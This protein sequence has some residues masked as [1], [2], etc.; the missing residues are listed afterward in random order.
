MKLRFI[1]PFFLTLCVI[2]LFHYTQFFAVKFYPV[3]ANFTAFAVFFVSSFS[4]ETVIQKFAKMLEG[5]TLDDFTRNYTRRLTYVWCVFCFLNL[6]ISIATVFMTEKWWA[7]YN[8]F[9]SYLALGTMF[10][11]EYIVRV[12]LRKK[13]QK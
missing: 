3:I 11:V 10:A 2:L 7:L 12:V 5:G 1:L 4:E 9:I 6:S 8:G 13:Y